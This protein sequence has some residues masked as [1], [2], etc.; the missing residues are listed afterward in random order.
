MEIH[1]PNLHQK[2][3]E[4]CD[5]YMETDYLS[6]LKKMVNSSGGDIEEDAIKYLALSLMF[7]V[8]EKATKLSFSVKKS[9]MKAVVKVEG[10][11][12]G[13]PAPGAE[14]GPKLFQIMRR[15]LHLE[16]DKGKME[17]S[18]G[19]RNDQLNLQVKI[20]R[21]GDKENMRFKLPAL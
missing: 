16:E 7:A 6:Q 2:L 14:I 15:I 1:D 13:L 11:K 20:E 21:E 9:V 18:L 5:C 8:T 10:D 17:L 19:L 12:I 4:M 3:I